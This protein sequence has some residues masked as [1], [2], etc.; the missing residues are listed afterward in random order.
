[1]KNQQQKLDQQ[2]NL[3][4]HGLAAA[5][6]SQAQDSISDL[7]TTAANLKA[8]HPEL[9][10]KI[11]RMLRRSIA[12]AQQMPHLVT[13]L[14]LVNTYQPPAVQIIEGEVK[15]VADEPGPEE[16]ALEGHHE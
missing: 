8:R 4:A 5:L 3:T 10:P 2:R 12:R 1:M 13:A 11:D 9:A 16:K 7:E 6:H 14:Y 15:A